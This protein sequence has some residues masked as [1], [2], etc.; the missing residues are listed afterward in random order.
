MKFFY[1]TA[2]MLAA[3]AAQAHDALVPHQHPHATSA[4]PSVEMVGAAAFV[5]AV[6]VLVVLQFR[7]R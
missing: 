2:A 7:R 3:T 6:A 1:A 5:V 4:L